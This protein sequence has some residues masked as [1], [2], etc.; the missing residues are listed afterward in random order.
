MTTAVLIFYT[1]YFLACLVVFLMCKKALEELHKRPLS[2]TELFV[3]L[4]SMPVGGFVLL[5]LLDK[6]ED[7]ENETNDGP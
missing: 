2:W 3:L 1:V 5:L 6:I 4:C 7:K